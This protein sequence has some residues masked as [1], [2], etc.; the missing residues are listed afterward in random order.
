[1]PCWDWTW[2]GPC[3]CFVSPRRVFENRPSMLRGAGLCV[4]L[5]SSRKESKI[6]SAFAPR[7]SRGSD[8]RKRSK[9]PV[10]I[11]AG[12]GALPGTHLA[13]MAPD[14]I[15]PSLGVVVQQARLHHAVQGSLHALLNLPPPPPD[16]IDERGQA[17]ADYGGGT[18][19]GSA[20][21]VTSGS[22]ILGASPLLRR[23]SRCRRHPFSS[24]MEY[25]PRLW[26]IVSSI[27][28]FARRPPP[29]IPRQSSRETAGTPPGHFRVELGPSRAH[30]GF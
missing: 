21:M 10:G 22:V 4:A 25:H 16:R 20:R 3:A 8:R 5:P 11:D 26:K 23:R 27:P 19:R 7:Y 24:T 12:G 13:G 29:M 18:A 9:R 28:R 14:P 6:T 30:S 15:L 17:S 1:M 2:A